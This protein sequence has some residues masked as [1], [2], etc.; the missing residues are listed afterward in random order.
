M[1]IRT[2]LESDIA[3]NIQVEVTDVKTAGD[4]VTAIGK[5]TVDGLPPDLVLQGRVEV[6]VKDGKV[7]SFSFTLDDETLAKLKAAETK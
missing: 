4:T 3:N 1:A 6:T 7:T 5:V 2:W